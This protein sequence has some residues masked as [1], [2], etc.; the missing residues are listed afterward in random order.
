[1]SIL[2]QLKGIPYGDILMVDTFSSKGIGHPVKGVGDGRVWVKDADTVIS[3]VRMESG[4][5]L[6][7]YEPFSDRSHPV[8]PQQHVSFQPQ[9][10]F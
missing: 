3:E 2:C 7:F 4:V 9:A 1:M 6:G 10:A 8:A 5:C